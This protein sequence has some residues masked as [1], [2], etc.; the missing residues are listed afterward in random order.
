M[1]GTHRTRHRG[2]A[3]RLARL[4]GPR[5]DLDGRPRGRGAATR[6]LRG[7]AR[8]RHPAARGRA[9]GV[10]RRLPPDRPR[11]AHGAGRRG[12]GHPRAAPR[13]LRGHARP[14]RRSATCPA[15]A[16]CSSSPASALA[17]GRRRPTGRP[18][19]RPSR[20]TAPRS[21][22]LRVVRASST[23]GTWPSTCRSS[24]LTGSPRLVAMAASLH[25]ELR[26]ALA[27]VERVRRNATRP[28]RLPPAP[29]RPA[30]G[31]RRRRRP[32]PSST[33]HLADAEGAIL[34]RLDLQPDQ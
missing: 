11:G 24:G 23:G 21:A 6:G 31:R 8:V 27:Q 10:A 30:R 26:L 34:E 13:R 25:A 12:P 4:G 28:G 19:A 18:S 17:G 9:G 33:R 2:R 22:A 16:R 5:A 3:L 20:S 32:T 7:R 29:A 14:R 1:T 15:R